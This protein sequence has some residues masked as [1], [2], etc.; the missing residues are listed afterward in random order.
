MFEQLFRRPSAIARHATAPFAEE[1]SRY[2][3]YCGQRGD[4]FPQQLRRADHLLWIA[5]KLSKYP[6]LQVTIDQIRTV[7]GDC[8]D[9]ESAAPRAYSQRS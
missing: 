2:L 6:D 7:V 5:R 8:S 3:E 1:R 4:S 9:G